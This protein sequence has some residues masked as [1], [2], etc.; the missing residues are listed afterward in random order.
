MKTGIIIDDHFRLHV[1]PEGFPERRARFDA[2]VAACSSVAGLEEIECP[3]AGS[4]VL[5]AVHPQSY[6]DRVAESA[7][8]GAYLGEDIFTSADSCSV[9]KRSAGAACA[10]LDA[11]LSGRVEV[12]WSL[13]RPPGHHASAEQAMGFC[14]FNNAAVAARYAQS[15]HGAHRVMIVDWDVHHGNGTQ[16]I[17]WADASVAFFSCHE[18]PLYPGTGAKS[19]RGEYGQVANAPLAAGDGDEAWLEAITT[20]AGRLLNQHRPDVIVVSAGFDAHQLDPLARLNVSTDAFA[21]ATRWL[22][23]Q[24]RRR[25]IVFCLEGGYHCEALR[26]SITVSLEA[27]LEA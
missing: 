7:E 15:H 11:V 1:E 22:L 13:G 8:T 10:G 3:E 9:A 2:V 16:A 19:E 4:S 24:A 26:D 12:A 20:V 25:P 5:T 23:H 21:Q 14:I 6:L 17:F 27:S 18:M